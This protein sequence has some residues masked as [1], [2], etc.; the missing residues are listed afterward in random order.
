MYLK[1]QIF[2]IVLLTCVPPEGLE[3]ETLDQA[4]TTHHGICKLAPLKL[5]NELIKAPQL[6]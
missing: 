3:T 6:Y 2:R 4:Q 1:D 5:T